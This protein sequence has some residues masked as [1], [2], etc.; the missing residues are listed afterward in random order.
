MKSL[1]KCSI[2]FKWMEILDFS[3]ESIKIDFSIA[4]ENK[5]DFHKKK[6]IHLLFFL[7]LD[8]FNYA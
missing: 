8:C 3:E 1:E 5:V 2:K 6:A 4:F 7:F